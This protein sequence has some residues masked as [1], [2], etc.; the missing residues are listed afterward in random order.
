MTSA[1]K[2]GRRSPQAGGQL[3]RRAF[4]RAAALFATGAACGPAPRDDSPPDTSPSPMPAA[5]ADT[6]FDIVAVGDIGECGTGGAEASAKIVGALLSEGR[7]AA[8]PCWLHTLG[9]HAYPTPDGLGG[10]KAA[11]ERCFAAPYGQFKPF[12]KPALGNHELDDAQ[13]RRVAP[14]YYEYFGAAAI[15]NGRDGYYSYLEPAWLVVVLNSEIP[16]DA[17]QIQFLRDQ[18]TLHPDRYVVLVWHR[19]RW[20]SSRNGDWPRSQAFLDEVFRLRRRGFTLHGHEH[21]YERMRET[22]GFRSFTIGTGGGALYEFK[23]ADIRPLSEFRYASQDGRVT[24]F[25][26]GRFRLNASG[27]SWEYWTLPEP[28][29]ASSPLKLADSGAQLLG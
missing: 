26:V 4:V 22:S 10:S 5:P 29:N 28:Q 27:Y 14:Y 8:R 15:G 21:A 2:R 25:G 13:A 24:E 6:G 9:D 23:L 20:G 11:F 12:I 3:N 16:G 7:A 17:R 19:P 1:K 18:L